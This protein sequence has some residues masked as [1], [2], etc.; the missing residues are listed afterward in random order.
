MDFCSGFGKSGVPLGLS[1][2]R[3]VVVAL[4]LALALVV[5]DSAAAD[6][7]RADFLMDAD[8][9]LELPEPVPV[10]PKRCKAL[11]LEALA[12]PEADMQRLAAETIA[13][14][15]ALGMPGLIDA[16]QEL[17]RIVAGEG[18][19]GTARFAA[20]RAL[21]VLEARSAGPVL[22]TA[23]Q[24][25]GGD[26]RQLIE[27]ALAQ[28]G[29]QPIGKIW[30]DRLEA[31]D[32]RPRDLMLAI[33]GLGVLS[34]TSA[35]E[36]L[37]AIANDPRHTPGTRFAAARSAGL[38]VSAGLENTAQRLLDSPAPSIIMRICAAT[39]LERHDSREAQTL[40]LRLAQDPEPGV[41]AVALRR[42]NAIDPELVIPLAETAMQN[43]DAEVRR[44]GLRAYA[45]RPT[46]ARAAFVIGLLDDQHPDVRSE[47]R[48]RLFQLAGNEECD[49]A[50]R[51]AALALLE[52]DGWR[53]Q[54]QAALLLGAL[55]HKPA[56]PRLLTLLDSAR[57]EVMVAAA[58][59]LRKL[60]LPETMPAILDK[61]A[62]L[63][64]A[65]T[66]SPVAREVDLQVAHLFEAMGVRK[67]TPAESLWRRY[68]PK[69]Y[70]MGELSRGAA[71]WALAQL[72]AGQ[73]DEPLARLLAERLTDSVPPPAEPPEM[74][75][76]RV[77][78]AVGLGRMKAA[79]QLEP[80]RRY[81]GV[82]PKPLPSSLAIR[83]AIRE[84]TG[85]V[86]PQ[87]KPVTVQYA[88]WFLVPLDDAESGPP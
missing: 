75:R 37:V 3:V 22:A 86:V 48:E 16:E 79:S 17:V 74:M 32:S 69:D 70:A 26:L 6:A 52:G 80:M 72:H 56:A 30:R 1:P 60:A 67:Y 49:A 13:Q 15:H 40:L 58:W 54:E 66:T 18:S 81:L 9:L 21:I 45:A 44:H 10:F 31:V 27:P 28:W 8:P 33:R 11:W 20:A 55:D 41:A 12:R 51:S 84:L 50:I 42:L 87:P 59:S 2:T 62:R 83:W 85:E 36:R 14:A 71:I 43:D 53:G 19:H 35:A 82:T 34:D 39:I 61:T 77:M 25:Y 57:G 23:A 65:R 38:I 64:N 46:A 47:A 63:T 7:I 88:N 29:Y 73:P 78:C 24:Q 68:I 5:N 76:V 4:L